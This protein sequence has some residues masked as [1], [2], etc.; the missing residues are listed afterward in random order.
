MLV[1]AF[2]GSDGNEAADQERKSVLIFHW[3]FTRMS[4]GIS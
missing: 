4:F 3:K 1:E 2:N